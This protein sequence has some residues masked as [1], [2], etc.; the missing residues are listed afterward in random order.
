VERIENASK[1]AAELTS[2]LLAT[3][4]RGKFQPEEIDLSALV[5]EIGQLLE[6]IMAKNVALEFD[7]GDDAARIHGDASQIRQIVMNLITN[8]ADACGD[9]KGRVVLRTG[10]MAADEEF[11]SSALFN[12]A[13]SP[14][15]FAY[16]E[17]VDNGCG[18]DEETRSKI[19]EPFF[20]TKFAGRGL[21]MAA[22]LG[23]VRHH[24]GAIHVSSAPGRG[25]TVRVLLPQRSPGAADAGRDAP[26]ADEWR[27][28]GTVL[29]VDDDEDARYSARVMVEALGFE[30][31]EASRGEEALD[32]FRQRDKIVGVL[33]DLTMPGMNGEEVFRNLRAIRSD[34]PILLSSGYDEHESGGR[35]ADAGFLQKPYGPKELAAKLRAAL[36]S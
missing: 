2:Q 13:G 28:T 20:T 3:T 31:L 35:V 36:E 21:G 19:F 25:T 26:P 18:M 27:G 30:V 14:G 24:A 33:L 4:G 8:A 5:R 22:V 10:V 6:T 15:D 23:I 12:G 32:L 11:L 34:V 7:I 1:R 17:A 29:V 9:E 16:V